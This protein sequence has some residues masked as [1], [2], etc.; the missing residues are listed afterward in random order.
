MFIDYL[1]LMLVN[2]TAGLGLLAMLVGRGLDRLDSK[3]WSPAFAVVGLVAFATGLHMTL[4]WPIPKLETANLAWANVAYGE[5]SV[6]FGVLFLGA[7][8]S[9]AKEWNLAP[10]AIYGVF[11]SAAAAVVGARIQGLHLSAAP[12]LTSIGFL[13][14]A[15]GGLMLLPVTWRPRSILFRVVTVLLLLGAAGIWG[16]T[17]FESYGVHLARFSR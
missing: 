4:T 3:T 9:L 1:T 6:L 2:M 8:V 10:M 16:V 7:S 11:A 5:M 14:T 12:M 15:F 13:M 17:A